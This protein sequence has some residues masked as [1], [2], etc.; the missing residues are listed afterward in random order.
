MPY[1]GG[2]VAYRKVCDAIAKESYKGFKFN[3]IEGEKLALD[4]G[5]P[6]LIELG[7]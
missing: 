5:T 4:F 1:A 6:K 3:K 2:L 7:V